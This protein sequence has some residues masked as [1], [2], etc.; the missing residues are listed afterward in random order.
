MGSDERQICKTHGPVSDGGGS[1]R[2]LAD[3]AAGLQ[4]ERQ[5]TGKHAEHW[6]WKGLP[7]AF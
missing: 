4:G 5:Q 1:Q 7:A 3:Q 2:R 6:L